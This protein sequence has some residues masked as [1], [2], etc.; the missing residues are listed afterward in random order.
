MQIL[1]SISF[2]AI[3]FY[4]YILNIFKINFEVTRF[5]GSITSTLKFFAS[6]FYIYFL[7]L[8]NV[9]IEVVRYPCSITAV[10]FW[11]GG[12]VLFCRENHN[13]LVYFVNRVT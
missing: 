10:V 3:I 9:N 11:V 8:L 1:I 5:M 12:G 7:D 4:I 13:L 2:T 6:I